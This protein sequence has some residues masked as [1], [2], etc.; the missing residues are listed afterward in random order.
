MKSLFLVLLLLGFLVVDSASG[1]TQQ[2]DERVRSDAQRLDVL[3]KQF[4]VVREYNDDLLATVYWS[5]GTIVTIAALLMGFGWFTNFRLVER[6]KAALQQELEAAISS[7][8]REIESRLKEELAKSASEAER[9]AVESGKTVV[10]NATRDLQGQL[11]ELRGMV[12]DL[13]F[14][15]AEAEV[16]KW[17]DKKVL[18]NATRSAATLVFIAKQTADSYRISSALDKLLEVLQ[19]LN[20]DAHST[21]ETYDIR[22]IEATVAQ[23]VSDYPTSVAGI[24]RQLAQAKGAV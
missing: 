2:A 5:L 3:E 23:L 15:A 6:E 19:R 4:E 17:L 13:R 9:K 11:S 16:S 21:L 10:S 12:H 24:R 1:S 20:A 8:L 22:E 7:Q 14:D 18:T